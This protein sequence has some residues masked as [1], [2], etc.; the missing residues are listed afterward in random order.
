M[1]QNSMMELS[2]DR[3]GLFDELVQFCMASGEIDQNLYMEYDVK[4]GLRDS[5]GKGVLTGLTEI[6]DVNGTKIV[7]GVKEPAPGQLYYHGY[8]VR[9]LVKGDANRRFAFEEITYLLLFGELPNAKQFESFCAVLGDLQE[10]S[11]EFVRDV[12]QY[13]PSVNIMNSLQKA[14]LNLYSFDRIRRIL[15]YRMCSGS[16]CR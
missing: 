11:N 3:K 1:Y 15:R 7:G 10:L 8:N 4:R 6:S 13:H 12:I 16:A 14:V 2:E 5:N 9:D